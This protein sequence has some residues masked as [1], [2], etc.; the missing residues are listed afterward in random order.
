MEKQASGKSRSA[1]AYPR[2][3]ALTMCV[4]FCI[5][6]QLLEKSQMTPSSSLYIHTLDVRASV[7]AFGVIVFRTAPL[8]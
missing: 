7:S 3:A 6:T 1:A 4:A 2:T 8:Q 5:A